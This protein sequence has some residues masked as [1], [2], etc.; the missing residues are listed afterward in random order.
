MLEEIRSNSP[1][2]LDAPFTV[3]E[4]YQS[5]IPYRTH[6]DRLGVEMNGDYEDAL[7][8]LLGG[9]GDYRVLESEPARARIRKELEDL[10]PNPGLYRDFAAVDVRLNP[11]KV[12]DG[13]GAVRGRRGWGERS[14]NA[15][16]LGGGAAGRAARVLGPGVRS[17]ETA[18]ELRP[19][20]QCCA[21]EQSRD[22]PRV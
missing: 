15:F 20:L 9:E 18:G 8:R 13:D 19:D 12:P 3:A 2:F 4:I 17:R 5:L 7:L 1:G 16:R 21:C 11:E 10:N 22:M 6:R 14:R